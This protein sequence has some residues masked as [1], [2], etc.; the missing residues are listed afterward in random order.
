[1]VDSLLVLGLSLLFAFGVGQIFRRFGIPQVIG[2][3]VAGVV[4][5]PSFFSL[6][7]GELN[8]NLTFISEI[9]LGLIGFDMGGH[10]RFTDLRELGRSILMIVLFEAIGAF[11][12]VS[13]GVY[14]ISG[15]LP[16]AL[17][18]GALA[19]ATAP[20]ATVDVLAE[21]KSD[22]PL[23]KT[24]LAVVGLDDAI[25]L[26]LFSVAIALAESMVTGSGEVSLATMIGLPVQE[27]G[28][29]LLVGVGFGGAL[30]WF[31]NRLAD[32]HD[33][34]AVVI[35][36]VFVVV[37]L[38]SHLHISLILTTM[39]MGLVVVNR[40]PRHG[41]TIRSTIEQA[42]PVVYVLFFMLTGARLEVAHLPAMGLL[43]VA[44]I[45]LRSGGKYVGAYVGGALGGADPVVRRN[46]GLA[47][48]SQAGVAIGLALNCQTRFIGC[49]E[50]GA[51]LGQL[52]LG[53]ITA[54]TLVVQIVGPLGV[55]LAI[56]RAG[57]IGRASNSFTRPP[58]GTA[59]AA[60]T[61]ETGD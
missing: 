1:M 36:V 31:M 50:E 48:L 61:A 12:L 8:Q 21:Y 26:L 16:T 37:G 47:L 3:I 32:H 41:D 45:L 57:E 20:A 22:G 54:T 10:L 33:V 7:P 58:V 19:S 39:I 27:I 9:A 49:G 13:V 34:M 43:G 55:K 24:L 17:I 35:G 59:T 29:S 52:V 6:V 15:L 2:F 44:Y 28:E 38:T 60:G 42:G 53:V 56:M 14:L 25:S 30:S 40:D 11:I 51:A 18:F 5:G 4:L 23:T 46:L